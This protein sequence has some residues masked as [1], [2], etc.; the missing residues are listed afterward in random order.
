MVLPLTLEV[1]RVAVERVHRKR[2]LLLA[3]GIRETRPGGS[4][5]KST[6]NI[7]TVCKAIFKYFKGFG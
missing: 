1:V 7:A 6:I 4:D 3:N 2:N 5:R